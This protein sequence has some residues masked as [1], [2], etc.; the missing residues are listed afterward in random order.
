[1]SVDRNDLTNNAFKINGQY[2]EDIIEGYATLATRGRE[3]LP[4]NIETYTIGSANGETF[5]SSRYPSRTIEVDFLIK[6][7][8]DSNRRNKINHLANILAVDEA[9]FVFN[10]ESDKYITGTP[11]LPQE[12]SHGAH[13]ISGTFSIFC[14][15]P[16]KYS[17]VPIERTTDDSAG[18]IVSGN[19]AVFTIDYDGTYECHPTLRAEFSSAKVGGEY[20]DDGDCGYVAFSDSNENVIQLGNPDALDIDEYTR[21]QNLANREFSSLS[22]WTAS[23]WN[24][25]WESK[26]IDGSASVGSISDAHWANGKGAWTKECAIPSFGSS[27]GMHGPIIWKQTSGAINY[28]LAI[29]QRLC[30]NNADE[31]GTFECGI[32]NTSGTPYMLTGYVIEKTGNG[33]TGIVKYIVNGAVVGTDS[34]DLSYYNTNFGYCRKDAVY[35]T[36]ATYT[37]YTNKKKKKKSKKKTKYYKVS[38]STVCTGY[39]YTQSNLNSTIKKSEGTVTFKVGNLA[40]KTYTDSSISQIAGHNVSMHFGKSG[41]MTPLNTNAVRSCKFTNNGNNNKTFADIPNVFTAGDIVEANCNDAS[42][43][44]MRGSALLGQYAPQF[45]ALGNDWESFVLHKGE[46]LIYVSWSDWV[47]ENYKP[48]IKIIYNE[49]YI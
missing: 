48:K 11:I 10:D 25:T 5:K 41:S 32:W 27:T 40:A 39:K 19:T 34:I 37:Y 28:D 33:T 29:E 45:G 2:L 35:T 44:M 38:Y 31:T 26:T 22:D 15:D 16:F 12:M 30:C 18:V 3:S 49:V 1:M 36:Y 14:M 8:D 7:I 6:D 23:G 20:N 4:I 42:V 47:E 17:L 24:K 43:Y 21:A 46:N 9:D 13:W